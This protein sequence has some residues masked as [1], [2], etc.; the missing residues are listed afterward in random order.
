MIP[1]FH[2]DRF[3]MRPNKSAAGN[4]HRAFSFDE[5]MEFG[6]HHCSQCQTPVAVPELER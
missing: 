5:A 2:M 4:R 6:H 3:T 1:L